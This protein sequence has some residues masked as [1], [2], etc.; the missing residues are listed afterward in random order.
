MNIPIM[1]CQLSMFLAHLELHHLMEDV[2]NF[3][4]VMP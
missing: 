4:D 1:E 3:K 2:E